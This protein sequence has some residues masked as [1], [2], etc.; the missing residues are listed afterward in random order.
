MSELQKRPLPDLPEST[1]PNPM[2][3]LPTAEEIAALR[4]QSDAM[5]EEGNH[6]PTIGLVDAKRIILTIAAKSAVLALQSERDLL[7][8]TLQRLADYTA[9]ISANCTAPPD[10]A[11]SECPICNG[12]HGHKPDCELMAEVTVARAA[13]AEGG[14]K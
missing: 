8:K 1:Q 12:E 5:A 6:L 14:G 9:G 2:T 4:V 11:W 7:R 10:Y 3:D 13:L